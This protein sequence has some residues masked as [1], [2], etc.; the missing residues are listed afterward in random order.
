MRLRRI[1]FILALILL[2][3]AGLQQSRR[4]MPGENIEGDG[5]GLTL[6]AQNAPSR[7]DPVKGGTLIQKRAMPL[8]ASE[9]TI[10]EVSVYR[11]NF[12]YPLLRVEQPLVAGNA[13]SPERRVMV[14]DHLMVKV[15]PGVTEAQLLKHVAPQGATIRRRVGRSDVYLIALRSGDVDVFDAALAAWKAGD[16]VIDYAEPDFVASILNA[17]L[18]NDSQFSQQWNLHNTGSNGSVADADI[19]APEAWVTT[20]GSA[21]VTVAVIDTGIDLTH[22]DLAANL[23][24]NPGESGDGKE[25]DGVDNDN[26]GY[27]DDVHG[28][29]FVSGTKSPHDDH[30]HG[31]HVS[32]TIG[33]VGGNGQGIA[34]VC[35]KVKLMGLKFLSASGSGTDSDAVEAILYATNKQVLA[36]NNSWG[37]AEFNQSMQDAISA[38]HAAGVGFVAASGNAGTNNDVIPQYPANFPV[39]NV[40]SVGATDSADGHAWFSCY[41]AATVHL[42][43]PGFQTYSTITNGGYGLMSGTSMAAPHVAGACAL[44]KAA[45]PL[46]SFTQIKT[47]LMEEADPKPSLAGKSITGGRLNLAAALVP[48]MNP[49]LEAQAL[50]IA[51]ADGIA[52]PGETVTLEIRVLNRGGLTAAAV[53]G[54]LALLTPNPNITLN[55]STASYGDISGGATVTP[56]IGFQASIAQDQTPSDIPLSLTLTSG[57]ETW[58]ANL[59]L[60]VRTVHGISGTVTTLTGNAAIPNARVRLTGAENREVFT[61]ENGDY[62]IDVTNGSYTVQVT[63][64]GFQTSNAVS[65]TL[66]PAQ[67]DMDFQLG[68]SQAI[69]SPTALSATQVQD[70][71]TTQTFTL[72]NP[73]DLPL[74]YTLQQVPVSSPNASSLKLHTQPPEQSTPVALSQLPPAANGEWPRLPFAP[75]A[76][77]RLQDASSGT[78]VVM[79]WADSFEDGLWGRWFPSTNYG[80]REVVSSTAGHGTKSFHLHHN[81]PTD[82]HL[83]GIHQWFAY[84]TQPG[85]MRWWVRPGA[86]DSA[87]CY[88]V[89]GDIIW[90]FDGSGIYPALVDFIWFFANANGRFYLNDDV[91]GNQLVAYQEGQWY[92]IE[93]REI[94]WQTKRFDYYVNGVLVQAGV[95]FRN[96]TQA[97]SMSIALAYN[98][99]ADSH[100]GLDGVQVFGDALPW[101]SV[102]QSSGTIAPGGSETITVTFDSNHQAAGLHTGGLRLSSSD[103]TT[104]VTSIGLSLEITPAPNNPPQTLPQQL[105]LGLNERRT[106]TLAATDADIEPLKYAIT[107]LPQAG[108][109]YQT[110]DGTRLGAAITATPRV[111]TNSQQQVIFVPAAQGHGIPY[112]TFLFTAEDAHATSAPGTVTLNITAYPR[113]VISPEGG[114]FPGPMDVTLS[115][116]DPGASIRLTTDGSDPTVSGNAPLPANLLRLDRSSTLRAYVF[117]GAL[118]SPV[119]SFTFS[120]SDSDSDG[121]PD[122]WENLQ[123]GAHA[124]NQ[125]PDGNGLTAE[126]EYIAGLNP[127]DARGYQGTAQAGSQ[128][129]FQWPSALGRRYQVQRSTDAK[130]WTSVGSQQW[131]TGNIMTHNEPLGAEPCFFRVQVTLP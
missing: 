65:L 8:D 117:N 90:V 3:W 45:N 61:N 47:M 4:E 88:I 89:L 10:T 116:T 39:N 75:P 105:D 122:W 106:I 72:S 68:F 31:T 99:F 14:A 107:A 29:N 50:F 53:S 56:A 55:P 1:I 62:Q 130:T 70:Q 83:S 7:A 9:P 35:H 104:S 12:K 59:T 32:G 113:L 119:Q 21:A 71:I 93:F 43:A 112:A 126:Q 123:P 92:Q 101:A 11:T 42:S 54:T 86:V 2:S 36:S 85:Y 80:V 27:I 20:T 26:N 52:S 40:I 111:V 97:S 69:V 25:A 118:A 74:S 51:D 23:W 124:P 128:M 46:L 5:G 94:N 18:P 34:G 103:P 96:P 33:A 38:A 44:L 78:D 95:P 22:P 49:S 102:S 41:G 28:W 16:D 115:S 91:G 37:G 110:P 87:T 73:G 79:P 127:G 48:A 19:D 63:K 82:E 129:G 64:A 109:L 60:K 24:I 131:G 58:T 114:S 125:D 98:Y 84:P 67:L 81:G 30:G 66:P 76:G 120:I 15:K 13:A 6:Q 77:S 121:L 57:T 100:A 108:Q 17:P